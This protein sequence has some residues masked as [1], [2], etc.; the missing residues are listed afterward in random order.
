MRPRWI[1]IAGSPSLA[2]RV[3][4]IILRVE[5]WLEMLG[6]VELLTVFAKHALKFRISVKTEEV[7]VRHESSNSSFEHFHQEH[8]LCDHQL[9]LLDPILQEHYG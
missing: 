4:H 3:V 1:V 2:S 7:V 6:L 9:R 8:L 5:L